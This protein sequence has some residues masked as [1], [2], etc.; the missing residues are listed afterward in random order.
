MM[1]LNEAI[2]WAWMAA[3]GVWAAGWLVTKQTAREEHASSQVGHVVTFAIAFGLLFAPWMRQGPLG[4]R[5][6]PLNEPTS[7]A[8]LALTAAG[9]GIAI[10]ARFCLGRNWSSIVEL[11]RGHTL[12]RRGPYRA[13][14][15]PMYAGFLMAMVGSALGCGELGALLGVVVAFAGWLAKARLEESFL[16]AQFPEAYGEYRR[17]VRT[18]IPFVL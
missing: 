9:I 15:H 16:S 14:R 3:A 1:D 8:A 18:L 13:V 12:V 4:W 10:W 17:Q 7:V 2:R 11:K 6:I 5:V